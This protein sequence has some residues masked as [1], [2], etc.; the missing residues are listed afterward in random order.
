M[1]RF[2]NILFIVFLLIPSALTG[3]NT[4][5]GKVFDASDKDESGLPGASVIWLGTTTGTSTNAAGY[6]KLRRSRETDML[7]ISFIGYRS[8]TITIGK[9]D[10]YIKTSLVQGSELGEVLVFGRAPG[11]HINRADPVLTVNIPVAELRKAACCNLSE[12]FETSAS[13]DVNYTDAATGAKQIQLLGLAG[14]YTQIL[15]ENIPSMYGLAS[16]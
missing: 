13:V 9:G 5:E 4:I 15:T 2:Y 14:N 16:A 11:T 10:D 3:Q 7:V 12:S 6:F 1:Y 8:D